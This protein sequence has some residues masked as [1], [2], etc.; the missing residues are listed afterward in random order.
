MTIDEA[1]RI[2]KDYRFAPQHELKCRKFIPVI[3]STGDTA[4]IAKVAYEK[5]LNNKKIE[6]IGFEA[7]EKGVLLKYKGIR[8]P[9][10][11][12]VEFKDVSQIL[13]KKKVV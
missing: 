10:V 13:D 12:I 9:V 4:L 7:T 8:S 3:T 2:R 11:G 5:I 6:I 1:E